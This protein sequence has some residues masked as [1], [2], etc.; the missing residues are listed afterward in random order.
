MKIVESCTVKSNII[1]L[2]L[3]LVLIFW[4]CIGTASFDYME[5]FHRC[6]WLLLVPKHAVG[7]IGY[8]SLV[9]SI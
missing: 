4:C 7:R 1:F 2:L 9:T 6:A 5:N 3:A 8:L